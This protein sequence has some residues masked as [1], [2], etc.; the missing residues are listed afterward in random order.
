MSYV[1]ER[2]EMCVNVVLDTRETTKRHFWQIWNFITFKSKLQIILFWHFPDFWTAN[3]PLNGKNLI[4]NLLTL[5]VPWV[6]VIKLCSCPINSSPVPTGYICLAPSSSISSSSFF[7]NAQ[8][9]G[10]PEDPRANTEKDTFLRG[11]A[12]PLVLQK[13]LNGC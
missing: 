6:Q 8:N 2:K 13:R 10:Y 5:K 7:P 1:L 9:F 11:I 12:S 4:W 3:K